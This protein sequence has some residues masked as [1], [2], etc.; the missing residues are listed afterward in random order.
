MEYEYKEADLFKY[1][2]LCK[3]KDKKDFEDP[4]ND[5]L[6][7]PCNLHSRKPVNFEEKK[8]R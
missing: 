7:E 4:C 2:N 5:C 6:A 1:C 3:Y 8:E